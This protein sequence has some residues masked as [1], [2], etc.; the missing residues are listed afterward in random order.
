VNPLSFTV[1]EEKREVV[2]QKREKI[3]FLEENRLI[4]ES[5]MEKRKAQNE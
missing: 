1:V 4:L 3:F 5:E 2:E